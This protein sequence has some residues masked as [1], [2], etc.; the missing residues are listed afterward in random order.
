MGIDGTNTLCIRGPEEVLKAILVAGG[1]LKDVPESWRY[2]AHKYFGPENIRVKVD[3]A[4]F[5][6]FQYDFRNDVFTE[7]LEL[8]LK[9]NPQCWFKNSY[10]TEMGHHGVWVARMRG[11]VPDVQTAEWME[12]SWEEMEHVNDFSE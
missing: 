7:Y 9:E 6:V 2:V 4:K 8:L 1:R 5:L 12:L 10:D 11:G 3:T